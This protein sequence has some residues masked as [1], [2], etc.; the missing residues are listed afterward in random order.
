MGEQAGL[1]WYR[2]GKESMESQLSGGGQKDPLSGLD[3]ITTALRARQKL[4]KQKLKL[5]RN[6]T[7]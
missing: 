1:D 4:K 2:M 5:L 7:K 3:Q 6:K